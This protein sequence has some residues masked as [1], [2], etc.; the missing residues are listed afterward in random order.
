[1][2]SHCWVREMILD[3]KTVLRCAMGALIWQTLNLQNPVSMTFLNVFLLGL[4]LVLREIP[5]VGQKFL[6]VYSEFCCMPHVR[7][8]SLDG[9]G[10]GSSIGM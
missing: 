3:Y 7:S 4:F 8:L 9:D 1:M 5:A 10:Q 6:A 2:V